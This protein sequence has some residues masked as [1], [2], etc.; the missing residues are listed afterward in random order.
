MHKYDWSKLR[1][2]KSNIADHI[3]QRNSRKCYIWTIA[4]SLTSANF[5]WPSVTVL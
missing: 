3:R 4:N 2:V 5:L 1:R